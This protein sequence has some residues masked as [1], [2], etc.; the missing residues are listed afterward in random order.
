M[1]SFGNGWTNFDQQ[2]IKDHFTYLKENFC[3][4]FYNI[5]SASNFLQ[6]LVIN[7]N[8]LTSFWKVLLRIDKLPEKIK[9]GLGNYILRSIE[10]YCNCH[11]MYMSNVSRNMQANKMQKTMVNNQQ[12]EEPTITEITEDEFQ[13]IINSI[14]KPNFVNAELKMESPISTATKNV[15]PSKSNVAFLPN[16]KQDIIGMT[17]FYSVEDL[18]QNHLDNESSCSTWQKSDNLLI[19]VPYPNFKNETRETLNSTFLMDSPVPEISQPVLKYTQDK[20]V[21]QPSVNS[22]NGQVYLNDFC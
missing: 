1:S 13:E 9:P 21:L 12:T 4:L 20:V 15:I 2:E 8:N 17:S 5:F 18:L 16:G 19:D 7:E 11:K 22:L 10:L 14:A 6:S 3:K